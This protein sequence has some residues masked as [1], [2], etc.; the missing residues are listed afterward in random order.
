MRKLFVLGTAVVLAASTAYAA[1]NVVNNS[2]K[3][4]LLIL[5]DIDVTANRTTIV[6]MVNDG[7][8]DVK[9]KCVYVDQGNNTD[10]TKIT[11]KNWSDFVITLTPRQP[12]W[13]DAKT[14]WGSSGP[15]TA[16]SFPTA[17]SAADKGELICFAITNTERNKRKFNHLAAT[18]TVMDFVDGDAYEYTAHAFY[19]R[20]L[21]A[22]AT[23][24]ALDGNEYDLCPTYL[25]GQF[26][27]VTNTVQ[28]GGGRAF[29]VTLNRV[30]ISSCFQQPKQDNA[31]VFTKLEFEVWNKHEVKFTGAYKCVD[32]WWDTYLDQDPEGGTVISGMYNRTNFSYGQLG[33]DS[34]YYRVSG[35]SS[36]R[37]APL[38]TVAV[39]LLGTQSSRLTLTP[40]GV[41]LVGTNVNHAGTKVGSIS[42][43]LGSE[44]EEGSIR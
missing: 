34:A 30:A 19:A 24:L 7:D 27:P 9:V 42:W 15:G 5:T 38:T 20:N 11:W 17:A 10:I 16:N 4:S 28:L 8:A 12:V 35:V 37:C 36:I 14:G 39:G 29:A 32:S 33:T 1:P 41:A 26:G 31:P 18:A 25:L 2:Q 21:T 43:A 13:F 23:I 44:T 22:D 6:R 3:G 40:G